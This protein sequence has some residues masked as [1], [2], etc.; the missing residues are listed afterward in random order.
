MDP[1][2]TRIDL[3][4]IPRAEQA[5]IHA[6]MA[7]ARFCV[8]VCHRRFG[9]TVL[10]IM[11]LINAALRFPG[12]D[13]RFGYVAPLR[14]QAKKVAWDYLKTF[15][16]PVP[17]VKVNESDLSIE[18]PN[19]SRIT[20]FGADNPDAMRGL[21]LDGVCL[22][23]VADMKPEV[24]EAVIRP[25]LSDRIGW[26]LFI[27]TPKG[28]NLFSDLYEMAQRTKGW[29]A[30]MF[31][32]DETTC[33]DP[34]ELQLARDAMS[35]SLYRQE[36]LCDF[37]A[38]MDNV[39]ITI[40]MVSDAI[41][42]RQPKLAELKGLPRILGVDVARFGDDKSVIQKRIGSVAFEPQIMEKVDN[43]TLASIV[44]QTIDDWGPDA[45]FIDGGRGEGVIDRLRQ[46]GY[47]VIEINFGGKCHDPHYADMRSY[48]WAKMGEHVES[49]LVL[50]DH[51]ALKTDL[52]TPTYHF[53][54]GNNAI[55]LEPKDRIKARIGRSTDPGDA[56][57]LTYAAPVNTAGPGRRLPARQE[58]E[59]TP[60]RIG[61]GQARAGK[62]RVRAC[63]SPERRTSPRRPWPTTRTQIP[64]VQQQPRRRI[65]HRIQ[66][67][68][69]PS[70]RSASGSAE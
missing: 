15:S 64:R 19:G 39:L 16:R 70:T 66:R 45:V 11:T 1:H 43:M 67:R 69:Q 5:L 18:F 33:L 65:W 32:A 25:A 55:K 26:A 46:L 24:W 49:N 7:T 27:G 22:D 17:G 13:G 48:M 37:T 9:K 47:D 53:M 35:D 63:A 40:D 4:Y 3:G 23:E 34:G 61:P 60:G 36:Y 50:P 56:L 2:P 58:Y 41:K 30:A 20:L 14:N 62:R 38:S 52:V 51:L 42:R 68:T 10:A 21:Y 44:A 57:A 31:R 12:D 28:I 59:R 6:A 8:L 54:P 29:H